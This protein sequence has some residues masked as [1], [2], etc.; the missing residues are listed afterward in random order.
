MARKR[1]GY[2]LGKNARCHVVQIQM[3]KW[4]DNWCT[5]HMQYVMDC[6]ECGQQF[7]SVRPH[8]KY[9]STAC[10]QRAYRN[11]KMGA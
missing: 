4:V 9:C 3:G 7:H 6:I 10:S 5:F 2:Y 1:S 11:R 8:T